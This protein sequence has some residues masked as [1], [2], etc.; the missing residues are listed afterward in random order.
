MYDKAGDCDD[1]RER[2]KR[3]GIELICPPRRNRKRVT[4]DGRKL[5]RYRRR[6]I[7]KHTFSWIS[8]FR[9]LVV[10]YERRLLMYQ[11]FLNLA[12]PMITLNRL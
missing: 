8:N 3:R 4:Q 1:L 11:A 6:W 5:R 12:C 7:V 10:R 2:L 9:R